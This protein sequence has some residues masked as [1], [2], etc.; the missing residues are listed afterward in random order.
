MDWPAFRIDIH[1]TTHT[2]IYS[3]HRPEPLRA[4]WPSWPY[5]KTPSGWKPAAPSASGDVR[6]LLSAAS[7]QKQGGVINKPTSCCRVETAVGAGVAEE[8]IGR[9]L[10][11]HKNTTLAQQNQ[12]QRR[13]FHEPHC[14]VQYIAAEYKGR[15]RHIE[16]RGSQKSKGYHAV[17]VCINIEDIE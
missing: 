14:P 17:Q 12:Q 5:P 4:P 11:T 8:S 15:T 13:V 2:Y 1:T 16:S 6:P 3:I 10:Q 7:Q 9:C